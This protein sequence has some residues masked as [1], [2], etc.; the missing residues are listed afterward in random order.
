MPVTL[1]LLS[2]AH[3]THTQPELLVMT[4]ILILK[5]VDRMVN[6]WRAPIHMESIEGNK[7][8]ADR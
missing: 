7:Y 8:L 2:L 6:K 3:Q 5:G 4:H 1:V